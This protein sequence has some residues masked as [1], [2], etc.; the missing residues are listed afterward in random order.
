MI[1]HYWLKEAPRGDLT[2]TF[3]DARGRELRAFTS[4][5]SAMATHDDAAGS[6]AE[7]ASSEEVG[8]TTAPAEADGDEEPRPTKDAGA[9]RFVWN[10][11]G[12]AATKLPETR[13]EVERSR[14]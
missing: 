1:V 12:P 4:R 14:C 11:R 9:N 6:T 10:L 2:L 8:V 13:A 5:S 3:L 7:A